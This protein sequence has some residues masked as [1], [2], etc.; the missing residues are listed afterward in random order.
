MSDAK[1]VTDALLGETEA[2]AAIRDQ[3]GNYF[4]AVLECSTGHLPAHTRRALINNKIEGLYP[5]RWY[6]HG[7]IMHLPDR[8]DDRYVAASVEHPELARIIEIAAIEGFD[9]I[10]FDSDADEL[11]EALGLPTFDY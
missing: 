3:R 2:R 9:L 6:E 5:I 10:H 11:P 1:A 4:R 7:W 8:A